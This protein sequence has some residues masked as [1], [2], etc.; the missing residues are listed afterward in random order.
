GPEETLGIGIGFV[1]CPAMP[2]THGRRA[3]AHTA[4]GG[5]GLVPFGQLNAQR[6]GSDRMGVSNRG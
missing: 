4:V 1:R 6:T 5:D 2:V 3:A